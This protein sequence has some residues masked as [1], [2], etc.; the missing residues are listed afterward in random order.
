MGK[1]WFFSFKKSISSHGDSNIIRIFEYLR[2]RIFEYNF[3]NEWQRD[4]E[5]RVYGV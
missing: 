1:I 4:S 5:W 2:G 3:S